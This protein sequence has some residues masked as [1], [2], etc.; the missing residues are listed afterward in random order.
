MRGSFLQQG[1]HFLLLARFGE[2]AGGSLSYI[3]TII[4]CAHFF[5]AR[6]KL[7]FE[8]G[9]SPIFNHLLS[10]LNR[11]VFNFFLF[12]RNCSNMSTEENQRKKRQEED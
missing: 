3:F 6:R 7:R 9:N 11:T 10:V 1:R 4:G 5:F 8:P 12:V 2:L